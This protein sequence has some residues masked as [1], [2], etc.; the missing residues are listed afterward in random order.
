MGGWV[1][2]GCQTADPRARADPA[3]RIPHA[4]TPCLVQLF[5]GKLFQKPL[6]DHDKLAHTAAKA[7]S[8]AALDMDTDDEEDHHGHA[9]HDTAATTTSTSAAGPAAAAAPMHV[10]AP[11]AEEPTAAA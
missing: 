7:K 6:F 10:D 11:A 9:H 2:A 4:H 1:A 8:A 3:V 5:A